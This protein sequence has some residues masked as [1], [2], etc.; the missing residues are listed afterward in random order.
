MNYQLPIFIATLII[1]S[2]KDVNAQVDPFKYE[3]GI[4][5]GSYIYQGDL[6]PSYAGSFK[7]PG[8][9]IG[10][11][12]TRKITTSLSARVEFN[13]G[14]LKGDDAKFSKPEWRS[15]RNFAFETSINELAASLIWI[16]ARFNGRL[17]PYVFAGAGIVFVNVTR[18]YSNYNPE[19]FVG[20]S[21]TAD[22]EEDLATPLPAQIPVIPVGIGMRY[23]ISERFSIIPEAS[24]RY[25]SS[26]YID[27]YSKSGTP[28]R[29]DKYFKYSI[30]LA[31]SFWNKSQ[32]GCPVVRF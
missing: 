3:V 32:Y 2:T 23:E 31:Y 8:L 28:N 12:V 5:V 21:V 10:M 18:D 16:P 14:R 20:T 24:F 9:A 27:G 13:T 11:Q 6:A 29:N 15:Q 25:I 30:G 4:N 19:Y 26:D 1:F 17:K 22:L 7:T